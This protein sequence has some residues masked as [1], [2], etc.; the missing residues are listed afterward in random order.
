MKQPSFARA[1][2]WPVGD[3]ETSDWLLPPGRP[4]C[5]ESAS[6]RA[7]TLPL[8][9]RQR[10]PGQRLR[11]AGERGRGRR[12]PPG[13]P[14]GARSWFRRR[15]EHGEHQTSSRKSDPV[16]APVRAPCICRPS[17]SSASLMAAWGK[18]EE[19]CVHTRPSTVRPVN[20]GGRRPSPERGVTESAEGTG[21]SCTR[22]SPLLPR[23]ALTTDFLAQLPGCGPSPPFH[24]ERN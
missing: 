16:T 9:S 15:P 19:A 12:E 13:R 1:C 3:Y 6:L 23:R 17:V 7:S 5:P 11:P 10:R 21:A 14:S 2:L 18:H 8:L 4:T 22:A 20:R 24:W